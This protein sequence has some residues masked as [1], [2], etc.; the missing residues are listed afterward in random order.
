MINFSNKLVLFILLTSLYSCNGRNISK[1]CLKK[2]QERPLFYWCN[3]HFVNFGDYLSLKLVERIV[4]KPIRTKIKNKE[5]KLLAVGSIFAKASEG[6]TIWGSGVSGKR[7]E[8]SDYTFANLDIRAVRGPLTREFIMKNFNINCPEI[9]GDPVLLLPYFFPE[10][11][12]KKSPTYDYIIIPHYTEQ[13]LFPKDKYTNVVYP[14]DPWDE[15]IKKI[16]D[17]KFV[18]AS[19]M[20]GLIVAEAFHV[21]ARMLRITENEPLFKYQDYYAGTN[22]PNFRFATSVEE[23]LEMGGEPPFECDLEKLYAAFPFD[24]FGNIT[25]KKELKK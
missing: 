23:A 25:N 1:N 17:S 11:K 9:Y 20:H 14:T 12:R 3:G 21:P 19:A 5:K 15:V 4:G 18:I 10:F 7:L 6:D 16:L 22:R 8:K 2:K 24:C 13:K